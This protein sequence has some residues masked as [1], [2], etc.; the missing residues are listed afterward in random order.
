MTNRYSKSRGTPS[1]PPGG[2]WKPRTGWPFRPTLKGAAPFTPERDVEREWS[3]AYHDSNANA[4]K[5][6]HGA[7]KA[8]RVP[9]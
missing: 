9:R 1:L 7:A 5:I 2:E 8:K 3:T 4:K 6:A